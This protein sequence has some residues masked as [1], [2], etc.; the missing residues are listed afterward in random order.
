MPR[1]LAFHSLGGNDTCYLK[2]FQNESIVFMGK[3]QIRS[4]L[5]SRAGLTA[6]FFLAAFFVS[7]Q[8]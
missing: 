1:K 8:L 7:D 3:N 2:A 6:L 5:S 4:N